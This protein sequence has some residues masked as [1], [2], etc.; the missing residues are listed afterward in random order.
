MSEMLYFVIQTF[1][2]LFFVGI[3]CHVLVSI[4]RP[5]SVAD[6]HQED[7]KSDYEGGDTVSLGTEPHGPDEPADGVPGGSQV[8]A[9]QELEEAVITVENFAIEKVGETIVGIVDKVVEAGE[10]GEI[11]T[12]AR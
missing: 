11:K 5:G 7:K 8:P 4:L 1:I 10:A 6:D 3:L 12:D 2:L 9:L